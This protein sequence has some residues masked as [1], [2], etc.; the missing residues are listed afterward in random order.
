MPVRLPRRPA[1]QL[2]R[3]PVVGE[4]G[5]AVLPAGTGAGVRSAQPA[6]PPGQGISDR[7]G[8]SSGRRDGAENGPRPGTRCADCQYP[9][10][11]A[12]DESRHVYRRYVDQ[13]VGRTEGRLRA[14]EEDAERCAGCGHR[15]AL[16]RDFLSYAASPPDAYVA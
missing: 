12:D 7:S 11:A 15:G 3:R 16:C 1:D 6:R 9:L 14:R 10:Y 4:Y 5:D 13:H 2:H 8:A